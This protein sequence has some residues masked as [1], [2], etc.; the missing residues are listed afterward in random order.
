MPFLSLIQ[1]HQLG[2]HC[3]DFLEFYPLSEDEGDL[4]SP[5]IFNQDGSIRDQIWVDFDHEL[6]RKP[7][8]FKVWKLKW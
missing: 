7:R 1:Q 5:S 2:I 3:Y 4:T 8:K 6:S